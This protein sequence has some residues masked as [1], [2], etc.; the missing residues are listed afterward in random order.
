RAG[1]YQ[2]YAVQRPLGSGVPDGVGVVPHA[3]EMGDAAARPLHG[4]M[5]GP[6]GVVVRAHED[7]LGRASQVR[8]PLAPHDV[9][10]ATHAAGGDHHGLGCDGVAGTTVLVA[11]HA[12]GDAA[13]LEREL[14]DPGPKAQIEI[15]A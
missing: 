1:R 14:G 6:V 9:E 15:A 12:A 13:V 2:L 3:R 7:V 8:R 5:H 4:L 11:D 10:V